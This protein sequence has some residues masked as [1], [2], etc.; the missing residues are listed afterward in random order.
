MHPIKPELDGADLTQ[1]KDPNGKFLFV[2]FVKDGAGA[3]QGFVDYITAETRRPTSP[4]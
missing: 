1:N 2:E 3:R 4:C